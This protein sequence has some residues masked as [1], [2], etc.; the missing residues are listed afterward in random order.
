[1][2]SLGANGLTLT[3]LPDVCTWMYCSRPW[4]A[5]VGVPCSSH[6]RWS[7]CLRYNRSRSHD[8]E[9]KKKMRHGHDDVIKWKHFPCYWPFVRGIHR[10]PVTGEFPTQRAVTRSLM[11]SL[12]CAWD[13]SWAN[14]GDAGDLRRYRAHYDVIVMVEK[15]PGIPIKL[16]LFLVHIGNRKR[17]YT[18]FWQTNLCCR[19][20][21]SER[22][23][24]LPLK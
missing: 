7:A 9:W 3:G 8:P 18:T 20:R 15:F 13:D 21:G 17:T 10:S 6:R 4:R 23:L 22:N 12:I 1:M 14:N 24:G 5:I 11:F 19:L 16:L 2:V